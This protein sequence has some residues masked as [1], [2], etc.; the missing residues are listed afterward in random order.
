MERRVSAAAFVASILAM[1]AGCGPSDKPAAGAGPAG[2]RSASMVCDS[3][4]DF[5]L[6]YVDAAV[7]A[8]S[9]GRSV[10]SATHET[11]MVVYTTQT[12]PAELLA[13][14]RDQTEIKGLL[15]GPSSETMYSA[16]DGEKRFLQQ[17]L[18]E[19]L[20]A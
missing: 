3:L 4:P 15:P 10:L 14:Y 9:K 11:G 6:L 19:V 20:D 17:R 18:R 2:I 5:A 12:P 7:A 16:S 8:C 1:L 13:W